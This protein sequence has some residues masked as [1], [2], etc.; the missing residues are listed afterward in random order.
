MASSLVN[1]RPA[2]S[3]DLSDRGLLYG[4]G[5]FRTVRVH[6]ARPLNWPNHYMRLAQDCKALGLVCPEERVL[7]EEIGRVAAGEA[8]AVAKVIVTRGVSGRGYAYPDGLASTRIV[9][10]HPSPPDSS[11]AAR[12]GVR[13]RR[14]ELALAR[15]PRLAGVKSLNRLEN[16]LARAEWRDPAIRE[17]LIGDAEGRLVEG[18]MSNVF[19]AFGGKLVTPDLSR[20]GVVGAQRE[21]IRALARDQSIPCEVRDVG[22]EELPRA[23]EVFLCNSLIG[24]WPVVAMGESRWLP[25]PVASLMQR[26]IELEDAR[27]G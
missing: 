3:V 11:G 18:T 9:V 16:V 20:C 2:L 13:V 1:G 4:D 12:E 14:C 15:Q 26:L 8:S 5:V 23:D 6:G 10:A 7:L 21:R 25:G 17:G 22:F 24:I 27:T 19:L